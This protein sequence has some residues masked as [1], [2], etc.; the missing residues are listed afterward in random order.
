[1]KKER[2][3][4]FE[5]VE[6]LFRNGKTP[7]DIANVKYTDLYGTTHTISWG[8]FAAAARKFNYST[9]EEGHVV[10][11]SLEINGKDGAWQICRVVAQ[12]P[13][14]WVYLWDASAGER[15]ID[16][17]EL[18]TRDEDLVKYMRVGTGEETYYN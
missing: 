5:T 13:E 4:Y 3:L 2:N 18:S 11:D 7:E 12:A 14:E 10:N 16:P 1:M 15:E 8:E 9:T 17:V 6:S